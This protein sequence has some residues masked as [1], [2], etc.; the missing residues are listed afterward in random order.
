MTN[1]TNKYLDSVYYHRYSDRMDLERTGIIIS[2]AA[3]VIVPLGLFLAARP[4]TGPTSKIL[5]RLAKLAPFVA[6]SVL[7][8]YFVSQGTSAA[9]I[10]LPWLFFTIA[11]GAVGVSRVLSRETLNDPG[12]GVDAGLMFI[13]VGGSWLVISR[14]GL[15]PLGF[16]EAIVELTAAHF[17]FA[18]FVLP[19]LAAVISNRLGRSV[20][21]PAATIVGVPLTAAGITAAGTTEFVAATFMA[22]VGLVVAA[23]TI[24]FARAQAGAPR[25]LLYIAGASLTVGMFLAIGWAWSRQFAWEYLDLRA[26][27]ITHGVLNAFGFGLS[28]LI[29]M[30]LLPALPVADAAEVSLHIGRPSKAR[31]AA[32]RADQSARETTNPIG[33]LHQEPPTGFQHKVWRMR[34]DHGN[35]ARA[36]DGIRTWAGHQRAGIARSPE[37]PDIRVGETLALSIP[38]GPISVSAAS[39]IIEV[40][41]QPDRYGF[42]YSTL[43]HHPVD[44][45]ESFIL[46]KDSDG[47]IE[48]TVTAIWRGAAV[49]N[50]IVPPVTRWLQNRAIGRYL[51]GIAEFAPQPTLPVAQPQLT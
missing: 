47:T 36:A 21:V 9:L 25:K 6:P 35:F 28:G 39:R 5:S 38:V 46:T 15:R 29:A 31:L 41:D 12:I 10:A 37:Q 42:T 24:V 23:R 30:H 2:F 11:V 7:L 33:L 43:P 51:K 8:S 32:I 19:I 16:S 48:I 4:E 14:A 1:L 49:A 40:V 44:G 26:M 17:H 22:I 34:I 50:D 27:V 45:E 13:V 3:F 18:G 20:A